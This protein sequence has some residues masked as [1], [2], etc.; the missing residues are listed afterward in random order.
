V[1]GSCGIRLSFLMCSLALFRQRAKACPFS[2]GNY[3]LLKDHI[4]TREPLSTRYYE[5]RVA[6]YICGPSLSPSRS[7]PRDSC[8]Y[9]FPPTDC[10][11]TRIHAHMRTETTSKTHVNRPYSLRAIKKNNLVDIDKSLNFLENG[12]SKCTEMHT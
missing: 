7:L 10:S 4:F 9:A 3:R 1:T 8:I 5:V 12:V 2:R 6:R 11:L